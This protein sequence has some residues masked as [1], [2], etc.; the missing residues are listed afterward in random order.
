MKRYPIHFHST[1]DIANFVRI[2]NQYD[3]DVDL[4][5]GSATMDAKSFLGILSMNLT[6]G[7]EIV[8][9]GTECEEM[10]RRIHA[11]LK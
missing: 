4:K 2:V 7:L 9:H 6:A 1:E 5:D 10:L 11:Y 3:F 8:I